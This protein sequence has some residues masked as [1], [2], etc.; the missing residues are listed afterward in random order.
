MRSIFI[1]YIE[2]DELRSP[3]GFGVLTTI[4]APRCTYACRERPPPLYIWPLNQY[5]RARSV[6]C[7]ES[8]HLPE[9]PSLLLQ[10]LCH[11]R[12]KQCTMRHP[13]EPPVVVEQTMVEGALVFALAPSCPAAFNDR[14]RHL[15]GIR[16]GSDAC[17]LGDSY[18]FYASSLEELYIQ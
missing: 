13:N 6:S 3:V 7:C 10:A 17:R 16:Y 4:G 2:R 11:L 1:R 14:A 12:I 9:S 5:A 18:I 8:K 15:F